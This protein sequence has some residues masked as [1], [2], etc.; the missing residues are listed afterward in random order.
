[1]VGSEHSP[2]SP[3]SAIPSRRSSSTVNHIEVDF[4]VTGYIYTRAQQPAIGT[5]TVPA[6]FCERGATRTI[7]ARRWRA[8]LTQVAALASLEQAHPIPLR[9]HPDGEW[10]V[11]TLVRSAAHSLTPHDMYRRPAA[12]CQAERSDFQSSVYLPQSQSQPPSRALTH[13]LSETSAPTAGG[14]RQGAL[15]GRARAQRVH[16]RAVG[17]LHRR[18]RHPLLGRVWRR[19]LQ[20]RHA[21]R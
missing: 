19:T 1:M 11:S 6:T 9:V 2:N 3:P 13:P 15:P 14:R 16:L 20:E 17:R 4:D 5:V 21:L 8:A 12:Q 7:M 10:T 18:G